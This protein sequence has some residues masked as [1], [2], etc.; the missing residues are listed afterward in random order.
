MGHSFVY[1]TLIIA[2]TTPG[3]V[4]IFVYFAKAKQIQTVC[5]DNFSSFQDVAKHQLKNC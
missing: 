2:Q 3:I 5:A 4:K 1:D